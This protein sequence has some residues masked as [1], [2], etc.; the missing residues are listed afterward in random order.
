MEIKFR[1][2]DNREREWLLGYELSDLGGFS[3][4][5]ECMLLNEWSH[6]LDTFLL[7]RDGHKPEDLIVMQFTGLL[8][9]D[10]K[11]IYDGD[12]LE[13]V[14]LSEW[15]SSKYVVEYC[16]MAFI[17]KALDA[18]RNAANFVSPLEST[19]LEIIGNI[20]ENSGLLKENAA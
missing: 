17:F 15:H 3:L 11:E 9:R 5:G 1:A 8:D 10:D 18:P 12:I 20:H 19:D 13:P 4:F 16:G 14:T 2:W 6:V 7:S